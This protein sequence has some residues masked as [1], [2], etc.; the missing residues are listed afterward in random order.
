M[1]NQP[2]SS[3][4]TTSAPD[5]LIRFEWL[6]NHDGIAPGMGDDALDA[7]IGLLTFNRPQAHNALTLNAMQHF[8]ALIEALAQSPRLRVLILTGAGETAFCSGGDL[9][10]LSGLTTEAEAWDFITVMGDALL[11][12][13]R[14]PVPVIAA[15][16]GHALG[17]GSEIAVACD[18]RVLDETARMGFVQIRWELTPGWGAGQRLLRLVGYA[19]AMELLLMGRTLRADELYRLGLVNEIAAPGQ[20]L[21]EAIKIARK[22]AMHTPEVVHGIKTLLHAGLNQP[23]ETALQSERAVFPPLWAADA[24]LNAVASFVKNRGNADDSA[25]AG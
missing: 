16:N 9:F 18:L 14:L 19:R 8:A 5:A 24:H 2:H 17:G 20:A 22:I 7:A 25:E 23:Y 15:V 11:H 10:E 3:L 4:L 1:D 6:P 21:N 12:L 13:E